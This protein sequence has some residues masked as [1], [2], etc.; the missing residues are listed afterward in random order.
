MK[1]KFAV[2]VIWSLLATGH[3]VAQ[4]YKWVDADGKVHFSDKPQDADG[5]QQVDLDSINVMEGGQQIAAS[6]SRNRERV[7]E[8][9][10]KAAEAAKDAPNPCKKDVE[11]YRAL[12]GIKTDKNGKPFFFYENNKD[13][14][15]MSRADHDKMVEELGANLRKRGCI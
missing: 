6:A 8:Q 15:P 9:Q 12:S 3:A 13:G 7:S 1:V 5:A 4:V 2:L 10:K 11:R 14:S